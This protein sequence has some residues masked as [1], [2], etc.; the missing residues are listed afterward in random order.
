M[1]SFFKGRKWE[2]FR[3]CVSTEEFFDLLR[4]DSADENSLLASGHFIEVEGHSSNKSQNHE[5]SQAK[6]ESPADD[7]PTLLRRRRDGE[8]PSDCSSPEAVGPV[9]DCSQDT[10]DVCDKDD[11]RELESISG[12]WE[13]H[14]DV[15]V[16]AHANVGAV[17]CEVFAAV[18]PEWRVPSEEIDAPTKSGNVEE[19]EDNSDEAGQSLKC[20][21]IVR[22][23]LIESGIPFGIEDVG[24]AEY[25]VEENTEPKGVFNDF[26]SRYGVDEVHFMLE[27]AFARSRVWPPDGV[28][29]HLSVC[30]QVHAHKEANWN[31]TGEGVKPAKQEMILTKSAVWFVKCDC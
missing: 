17:F 25:C 10:D 7:A 1:T 21:A 31:D 20:V 23:I 24:N 13:R 12:V 16:I 28:P 29:N 8:A 9:E 22:F 30:E 19:D 14:W 6:A 3:S 18:S 27:E 4:R 5:R 2:F 26:Q 15:W 11:P